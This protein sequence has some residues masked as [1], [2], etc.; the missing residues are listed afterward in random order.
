MKHA[1]TLT[2]LCVLFGSFSLSGSEIR[3]DAVLAAPASATKRSTAEGARVRALANFITAI[4][5]RDKDE[6]FSL[7]LEVL[8]DDPAAVPPRNAIRSIVDTRAD[9]RKVAKPLL[10][11]SRENPALLDLA[12]LAGQMC[13]AANLPPEEYLDDLRDTL[14]S[15][16]EPDKLPD[17]EKN[18]FYNIVGTFSS[19]LKQLRDYRRGTRFFSSELERE[20]PT[21]R[22]ML[23]RFAVDF[24][25]FFSRHGRRDPRWFGLADSDRKAA[26]ERFELLFHELELLEKDASRKELEA[27]VDFYLSVGKPEAAL[28]SAERIAEAS[29]QPSD[30]ARCAFAAIEAKQFDKIPPIVEALEAIDGWQGVAQVIRINSLIAQGKYDD[31]E[32]RIGQMKSQKARDEF[33]LNLFEKKKDYKGM[34]DLLS[35]MEGRTS[36]SSASLEHTIRQLMVAEQLKDVELLNRLWKKLTD[37]KQIE[38]PETANSVGYVAAELNVR[39]DEAAQL[40]QRSLKADPDNSAYLDSMAWVLYRQGR[41]DE[42]QKYID[43]AVR[44][45]GQDLNCGAIYEHLGD[46]LLARGKKAEADAAYREALDYEADYDFDPARAEAKRKKIE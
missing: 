25:F 44:A 32:K 14:D 41:Y 33:L 27:N 3:A 6:R 21:Y 13:Y 40:I 34:R 29:Q 36:S 37:T 20:T 45:S 8:R 26:E 35:L 15:V 24:E 22:L 17:D 46:I 31:A 7:L 18:A 23:L 5:C 19:A 2:L 42:A 30:K 1:V 11:I 43:L 39:L 16:S 28:R 38:S 12:A 4:K 9:A 10:E